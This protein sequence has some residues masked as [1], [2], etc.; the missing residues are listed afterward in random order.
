MNHQPA[1]QQ[2]VVVGSGG[3]GTGIARLL[4]AEGHQVTL[5]SRSGRGEALAGVERVPLDLAEEGAGPRLTTLAQGA[6]SIVNALNPKSYGRWDKEWPPMAA[7]LLT[8]AERSGAGLVTVGNLYPYGEVDVPM[9]EG[10]PDR[11]T[12]TKGRVRAAMWEQARTAHEQGRIRATELRASD[13]FGPGAGR[14]VSFANDYVI[15]PAA[16]GKPV[17]NLLGRLDAPHSWTY[18][19]DI[20]R[21]GAVLATDERAW[22][23][24][25]HVP[26][27]PPR[28][29]AQ[30]AQ[31]AARAAGAPA[32]GVGMMPGKPL[33]MALVPTLRAVREMEYQ[34]LRPF[35]IDASLTEQTFG[36]TA[37][38][39]QE[40]LAATVAALAG[41]AA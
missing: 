34:F 11:P 29:I 6:T 39:W 7:H 36:L 14:G 37:T 2:H 40:A 33:L 13:Y 41:R 22:G 9:S 10:R 31:D 16:A 24:V 12:S 32:P 25:W 27:A 17:R 3:I 38:S 4:A 26:T 1:A 30:L 18:L 35:E 8:A 19:P 15:A 28:T 5:V 20:A 23:Q 21:L